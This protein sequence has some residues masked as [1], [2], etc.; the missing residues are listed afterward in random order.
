MLFCM[1]SGSQ[2][3]VIVRGRLLKARTDE[4]HMK[5]VVIIHKRKGIPHELENFVGREVMVILMDG[6]GEQ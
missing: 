3:A 6:G 1:E 2:K 5:Y 4:K